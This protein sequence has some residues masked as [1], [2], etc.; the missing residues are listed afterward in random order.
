MTD[1][2][3]PVQICIVGHTNTGKTS[4]IRTIMRDSGFGEVADFAGTTRHVEA[5]RLSIG[6]DAI[7]DLFDTPG[8]EDSLA[9][10]QFWLQQRWQNQLNNREKL[11][12]FIGILDS[13]PEFS[14]EQ[15]VL[16]Q[17]LKSDVLLYVI[18]ARAPYLGK[19]EDEL[20][21]LKLTNLPIVPVLNFIS[22]NTHNKQRWRD[23]LVDLGLH[24]V[25]EYDTVA[26]T[27]EAE[28]RLFEKMQTLAEKHYTLFQ[29]II[30]HNAINLD[31]QLN[32]AAQAIAEQTI[33]IAAYRIVVQSNQIEQKTPALQSL[34]RNAEQHTV[35][36]LMN[37]FGFTSD[38]VRSEFLPVTNGKWALD[39]F[40]TNTYKEFGLQASNGAAKGAAAGVG[41]DLLVGGASLGAGAAIGAIVGVIWNTAR[42]YGGNLKNR[43]NG[44]SYLR[45]GDETIQLYLLR[46]RYLLSCLINRGHASQKTVAV[47]NTNTQTKV[48][49]IKT[50]TQLTSALRNYPKWSTLN[51]SP[52]AYLNSL[53]KQRNEFKRRLAKAIL[54]SV[55]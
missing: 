4:L 45:V 27:L 7:L 39:L 22:A 46:Q 15:K 52:T 31:K 16:R 35:D 19:H 18:D 37:I 54:D 53:D 29:R 13:K 1:R 43:L 49:D 55:D 2:K 26:F 21:L 41:I 51:S 25:V 50:L 23:H 14:Q 36:Q 47:N 12:E 3:A 38:D 33:N 11:Y 34:I 10:H 44:A 40:D 42:R 20:R 6:N 30:D 28:R 8:L 48:E 24:A 9:L 32:S 5:A 17:A